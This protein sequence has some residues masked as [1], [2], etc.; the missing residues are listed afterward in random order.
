MQV[1]KELIGKV[2]ELYNL[3]Y[4][5]EAHIEDGINPVGKARFEVKETEYKDKPEYLTAVQAL[6]CLNQFGYVFIGQL[7]LNGKWPGLSHLT[8]DDF[9]DL[10]KK[11]IRI[12]NIKKLDFKGE[13]NPDSFYC[14]LTLREPRQ[15][16]GHYIS[17]LSASF[18]SGKASLEALVII[19]GET[20]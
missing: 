11:S 2:R 6:N 9:L 19:K 12:K 20:I 17:R 18:E 1:S 8:M 5:V 7:V 13:I 15:I 4:I 3:P 10:R 16:R 14:E